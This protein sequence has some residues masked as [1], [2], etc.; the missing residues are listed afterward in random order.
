M[1]MRMR[2]ANIFRRG[3]IVITANDLIRVKPE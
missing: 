2:I 1:R 3:R